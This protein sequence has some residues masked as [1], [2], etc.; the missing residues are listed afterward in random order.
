MLKNRIARRS[1]RFSILVL[2]VLFTSII[3]WDLLFFL[4]T[5]YVK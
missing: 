3:C 2:L 5:L 4:D 1:M